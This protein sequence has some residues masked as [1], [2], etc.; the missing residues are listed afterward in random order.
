MELDI[1]PEWIQLA[2][3][4]APGGS[5]RAP[6]PGLS[7]LGF[8]PVGWSRLRVPDHRRLSAS[9]PEAFRSHTPKSRFGAP[10]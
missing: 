8:G 2:V 7:G 5:L 1:N 3:S 10:A 4:R 6:I 9:G